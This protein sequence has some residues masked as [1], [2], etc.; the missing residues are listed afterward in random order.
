MWTAAKSFTGVTGGQE[1]A[2]ATG[3]Q[4]TDAAAKE[5]GLSKKPGLAKKD[6]ASDGRQTEKS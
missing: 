2:F 6:K 3:E 1:R 4:I 5:M